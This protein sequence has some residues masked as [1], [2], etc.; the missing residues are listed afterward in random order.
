M[1]KFRY[2]WW[3]QHRTVGQWE[4]WA[5]FKSVQIVNV[6]SEPSKSEAGA[7]FSKLVV[8]WAVS[9]LAV[10]WGW[11]DQAA[12]QGPASCAHEILRG[13][14][15]VTTQAGVS[16]NE[17]MSHMLVACAYIDIGVCLNLVLLFLIK[18]FWV[19]SVMCYVNIPCQDLGVRV[20]VPCCCL[21][22]PG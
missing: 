7:A 22:W 18:F 4:S 9:C 2:C 19:H 12:S 13:Y 21:G 11:N 6:S 1:L 16:S 20:S 10:Q 8:G 5:G 14:S 3:L 17:T 15:P